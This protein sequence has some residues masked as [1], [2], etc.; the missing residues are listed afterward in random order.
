MSFRLDN[1]KIGDCITGKIVKLESDCVLVDFFT[2]E[3]ACV[4][5]SELSITKIETPEQVLQCGELREFLV[6]GNYDGK[7]EIFFSHC[8]P[9]TLMEDSDRLYEIALYCASEQCGHPVNREDLILNTKILDV[10][11]GGVSARIQWFLCSEGRF[12][13]VSFSI[14]QL[15]IEQA[16]ERVRQLQAEDATIYEKILKKTRTGAIFKI[17]G[18]YGVIRTYTD[19][20]REELVV[21]LNLTL[22]ILHVRE[23]ED[24]ASI[25]LIQRSTLIRLRQLQIG[26]I[27]NGTVIAIKSYGVFVDI[28]DLCALLR[29]SRTL[30]LSVDHPAQVFKVGERLNATIVEIDIT[31]G[32]VA[33]E[34]GSLA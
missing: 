27:I 18:L 15:A 16:W 12:P 32:R 17:E 2:G 5:L 3:L 7:T 20:E 9:E 28:G 33:L 21:G 1:F 34:N 23:T 22:K 6:V 19:K 10:H 26:Q 11:G 31:N 4:P 30:N 25:Q 29:A 14:R 8:S 13:T 24:Y